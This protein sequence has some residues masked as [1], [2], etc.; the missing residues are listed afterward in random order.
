MKIST[1]TYPL[2][3]AFGQK[4]AIEVIA[5]A[6]FDAVDISV[7]GLKDNHPIFSADY[8]NYARE[9]LS[10]SEK[11]NITY[12]QGHAP[13]PTSMG[14]LGYDTMIFEKT[15]RAMEF[16]SLLKVPIIVVH[17]KQHLDY[18]NAEN[19]KRLREL[20]LEFYNRLI[21]YCKDFNIKIAT[22]NMWQGDVG[23]I[24]YSVCNH[25]Q[26]FKEYLDMINSPYFVACLDIGH[27][28]IMGKDIPKFIKTLGN[29]LETLHVHDT[30]RN[31]DLHALPY[32]E[33]GDDF[34]IPI[35]KTLAEIDYKGDLTL[36]AYNS[37]LKT[38]KKDMPTVTKKAADIA[39]RMAQ[40]FNSFKES[41]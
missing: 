37:I 40:K 9:L 11:L 6:G 15:L 25:P 7:F 34:W 3:S 35:L 26:E 30:K 19:I 23:N 38:D 20:N 18:S 28:N 24:T 16:C 10:I 12:N 14:E 2:T 27:A 17:P 8:K 1:N 22:E 21:P 13:H 5:N 32:S 39:K 4:G 29:K 31:F 36:E 33:N 41:R